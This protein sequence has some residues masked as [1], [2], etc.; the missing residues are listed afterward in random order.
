MLYVKTARTFFRTKQYLMI[1]LVFHKLQLSSS[2]E[3]LE[4]RFSSHTR[5]IAAVLFVVSKLMILP[6][7]PYVP[8]VA[9][10]LGKILILLQP[11]LIGF[12]NI[13]LTALGI[14]CCFPVATLK[15]FFTPIANH[16]SLK[17]K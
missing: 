16:D 12:F 7:V 5:T 1:F 6:I 15:K 13:L 17:Y 10:R 3:Y 2:F 14:K 4:I 8:M 9:F 11:L